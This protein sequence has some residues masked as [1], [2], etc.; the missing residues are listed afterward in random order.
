MPIGI[1]LGGNLSLGPLFGLPGELGDEMAMLVRL[2]IDGPT[3]LVAGGGVAQF[4]GVAAAF[5]ALWL[6][7]RWR[8][9]PSALDES[10]AQ[11]HVRKNHEHAQ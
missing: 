4:L 11:P 3:W 7:L 6:W 10:I 2:D 8:R 1:H 5:A 9:A